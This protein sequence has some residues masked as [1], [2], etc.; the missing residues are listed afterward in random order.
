MT[1]NRR[2]PQMR[3]LVSRLERLDE[4]ARDLANVIV[5]LDTAYDRLMAKGRMVPRRLVEAFRTSIQESMEV[6]HL[7]V[8]G[9]GAA[10]TTLKANDPK[11]PRPNPFATDFAAA[12]ERGALALFRMFTLFAV[13][14]V[15]LFTREFAA[16]W[17]TPAEIAAFRRSATCAR[18]YKNLARDPVTAKVQLVEWLKPSA[19]SKGLKWATRMRRIFRCTIDAPVADAFGALIMW[20]NEF[21]HL[22]RRRYDI[23]WYGPADVGTVMEC[24]LMASLILG[25]RLGEASFKRL[26]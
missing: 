17:L 15:E 1:A 4:T 23:D 16:W 13:S 9:F 19:P 11:V 12:P 26:T 21:A 20:R 3:R 7:F 24:A 5:T 14:E 8:R 18:Y 2:P 6:A 22:G 25:A 10:R